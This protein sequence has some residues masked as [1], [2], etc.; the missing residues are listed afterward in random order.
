[1]TSGQ[2]TTALEGSA[3][4][5]QLQHLAGRVE[6]LPAGGVRPDNVCALLRRTGCARS[7]DRSANICTIRRYPVAESQYGVTD[8]QLV[9]RCAGRCDGSV[10]GNLELTDIRP[11]SDRI[12]QR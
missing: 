7:T 5:S 10:G 4:I 6:I 8:R 12:G 9:R 3:L 2:P 1:M 11:S